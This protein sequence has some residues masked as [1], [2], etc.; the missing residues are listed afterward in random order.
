VSQDALDDLEAQL[1]P[2]LRA[3]LPIDALLTAASHDQ[4]LPDST[5]AELRKLGIPLLAVPQPD[6]LDL[7]LRS[8]ARV[9][10][11]LGKHLAPLALVVEA[12]LLAPSLA[13]AN[14]LSGAGGG[15][16]F[17]VGEKTYLWLS[18]D[19]EMAAVDSG[20]TIQIL[21]LGGTPTTAS[22]G[23]DAGQGLYIANLRDATVINRLEGQEA[24]A[25]LRAHRCTWLAHGVGV[26]DGALAMSIEY[27]SQREQFGRPLASFQAVAHKLAGVKVIVDSGRA[28]IARLAGL[29]EAAQ[30][31]EAD[32]LAIEFSHRLPESFRIAIEETIQVHGGMGFTW[33]YGLHLRYRRVLQIQAAMGGSIGSAN[34]AGE[35]YLERLRSQRRARV[36]AGVAS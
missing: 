14:R 20:D 5:S 24:A 10:M 27:T 35:R 12:F 3:L 7:D 8:R 9:A 23:V 17:K 31:D 18:D 26:V 2:A 11:L 1:E 16:G 34:L 28:A 15:G 22:H 21:D 30:I 29:I 4:R 13:Q 36:K 6:G 19:A 25:I 32:R 33:E